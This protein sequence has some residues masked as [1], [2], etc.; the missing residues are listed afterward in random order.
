LGNDKYNNIV[1]NDNIINKLNENLNKI[2]SYKQIKRDV[3]IIST[4]SHTRQNS[5]IS[6]NEL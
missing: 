3:D 5:D 4:E 6:D 1:D 2:T